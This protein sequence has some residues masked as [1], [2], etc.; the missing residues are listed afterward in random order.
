MTTELWAIVIVFALIG[1]IV[2]QALKVVELRMDRWRYEHAR[3]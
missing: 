1:V 3:S 2:T